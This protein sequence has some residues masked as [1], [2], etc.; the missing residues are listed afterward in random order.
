MTQLQAFKTIFI[1]LL[2]IGVIG[3]GILFT[4]VTVSVTVDLQPEQIVTKN[5]QHYILYNDRKLMLNEGSL[6]HIDLDTYQ[7][8]KLTYSYNKLF[9]E[10]GKV[11]RLEAYGKQMP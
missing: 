8:Y 2:L 11:E 3:F 10:K 9:A 6:Q 5:E 1:A 7:T 4:N